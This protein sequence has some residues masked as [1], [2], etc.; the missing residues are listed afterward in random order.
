M[1]MLDND[2]LQ[3]GGMSS[4]RCGHQRPVC[5]PWRRTRALGRFGERDSK[6]SV[7]CGPTLSLHAHLVCHFRSSDQSRVGAI[8][9]RARLAGNVRIYK[10]ACF[11]I[12][13]TLCQGSA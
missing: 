7:Q 5:E 6:R 12:T 9:R 4:W 8:V 3:V 2:L 11:L 1:R 10:T 13:D